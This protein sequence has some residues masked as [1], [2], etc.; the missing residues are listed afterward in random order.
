MDGMARTEVTNQAVAD[1]LSVS[2]ATIS[3]IR[4]GDRMPGLDLMLKIEKLTGW[5]LSAQAKA[6]HYVAQPVNEFIAR[7]APYRG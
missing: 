1:D 2:H 6:R 4:S 7:P 3:R 5:K